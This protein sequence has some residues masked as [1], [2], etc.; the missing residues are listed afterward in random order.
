MCQAMGAAGTYTY[1]MGALTSINLYG[2][3]TCLFYYSTM[4]S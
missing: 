1:D 4:F 2:F 3:I